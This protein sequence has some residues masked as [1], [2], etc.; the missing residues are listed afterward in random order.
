MKRPWF[1][2]RGIGTLFLLPITLSGWLS[3]AV[4]I[5]LIALSATTHQSWAWAARVAVAFAFLAFSYYKSH[6][7]GPG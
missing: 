6:K 7:W 3:L 5:A 2:D 1:S 4:F